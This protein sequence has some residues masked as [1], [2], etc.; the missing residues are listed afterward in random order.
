MTPLEYCAT[1]TNRPGSS[2]YY[3]LL[4]A[5]E[6]QRP[7]LMA[8][9]ALHKEINEVLVE[10]QEASVARV[11]L[12]WWRSELEHTLA[13]QPN[14]P[15]AKALLT[16]GSLVSRLRSEPTA[17]A[18]IYQLF[19]ELIDAAEM[20]LSQGRYLDWPNL[21]N[22]LQLNAASLAKLL[23]RQLLGNDYHPEKHA[24]PTTQLAKGIALT[25]IVRDVGL[26]SIQDRIYIPMSDLRRFN[27]TAHQI[28]QRQYGDNFKA[29]IDFE[30]QRAMAFFKA[31]EAILQE[32]PKQ[33]LRQ[34]HPLLSLA[35]MHKALLLNLSKNPQSAFE[36][37]MNLSPL[38]KAWIAQKHKLSFNTI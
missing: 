25:M 30:V 37:R 33:E 19:S 20:D 2:I 35:S 28:R 4:T 26:H 7:H 14:H 38:R 17:S 6:H 16:E 29:L 15:I 8:L 10:C 24:K 5:A 23:A 13:G 31:A 11:K 1:K 9:L 36:Y 32:L 27:V 18:Q 22:Y 34:L 21:D 12:A 3:A